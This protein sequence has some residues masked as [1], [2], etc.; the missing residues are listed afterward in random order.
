MSESNLKHKLLAMEVELLLQR[1]K[2]RDFR[3]E[4]AI[5]HIVYAIRK[6]LSVIEKPP[7]AFPKPNQNLHL[8]GPRKNGAVKE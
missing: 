5:N 3:E 7:D 1:K 4:V 2:A 8:Q 6:A